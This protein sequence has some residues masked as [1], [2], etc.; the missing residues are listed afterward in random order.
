MTTSSSM[1][2]ILIII[3]AVRPQ[4]SYPPLLSKFSSGAPWSIISII[5]LLNPNYN[6]IYFTSSKYGDPYLVHYHSR[7]RDVKIYI[8]AGKA[9]IPT[10]Q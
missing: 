6:A 2:L 9:I 10:Q 8:E 7:A 4:I 3:V 5:R 1:P